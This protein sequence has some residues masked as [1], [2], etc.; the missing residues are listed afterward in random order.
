MFIDL[1]RAVAIL[2]MLQGHFIDL[3]LGDAYRDHP[4]HSFWHH[5][6]GLAAPMFFASTGLI[7][8]YLLSGSGDGPL[9]KLPRVKKGVIRSAELLFWGYLLQID[10]IRVP[11]YFRTG[12]D[13]WLTAFHVLQCIAF[14]ILI[15]IGVFAIHR[16]L[17]KIPLPL[18]YVSAGL[19]LAFGDVFLFNLPKGSW[20]PPGAPELIQNI[21]KGP[22]SVFPLTPWLIFTMYGAA[23]GAWVRLD[24]E[25]VRASG[26]WLILAGLVLKHTG[27]F[28]DR[29]IAQI[30]GA[31]SGMQLTPE[32]WVHDRCGEITTML[33][34]LIFIDHRFKL[35]DFWLMEIG[36]NTLPIYI[37]HVIVLYNGLFGWGLRT[38]LERSLNPWQATLGA[39]IFM[40]AFGLFAVGVA[41]LSA[42]WKTGRQSPAT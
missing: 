11:D 28:I 38:W 25:K 39:L 20:M 22:L 41:R 6:R 30:A 3:T 18:L 29:G 40:T 4:L 1:A 14:G 42:W 2:M 31:V 21:I 36:R 15:L 5:F 33:G 37:V 16:L 17:P 35:R 23:L 8:V 34:V 7:F 13:H 24:P 27:I 9:L 32:H 12:P 10:L 19:V 26:P